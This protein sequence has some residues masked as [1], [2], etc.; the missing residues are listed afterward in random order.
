MTLNRLLA[1]I[2]AVFCLGLIGLCLY[3]PS[4]YYLQDLLA[5]RGYNRKIL[6]TVDGDLLNNKTSVKVIKYQGPDSIFLEI[7]EN[8][9]SG[10]DKL[11]ARIVLPD[12]HDGLFNLHGRVTGLA[13]ADI[14]SDG[15]NELLTSTFDDQLVPHLNI[16]RYS[17]SSQR[18]EPVKPQDAG[19]N[20]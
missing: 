12:K 2:I 11:L 3:S 9:S 17:P 1:G 14:D 18:F 16:Y 6:A 10:S 4:R 15:V 7:L 20:H 19:G 13:I 8:D 5:S